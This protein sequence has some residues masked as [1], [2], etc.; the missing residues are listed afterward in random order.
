MPSELFVAVT[1]EL[2][3]VRFECQKLEILDLMFEIAIANMI[4]VK[5]QKNLL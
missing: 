2:K 3:N 5:G 1:V 4:S